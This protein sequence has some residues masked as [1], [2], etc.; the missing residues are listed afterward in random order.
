MKTDESD[1]ASAEPNPV[2]CV[3]NFLHSMFSPLNVSLKGKPFTLQETDYY[4]KAYFEKL[5]NYG[6]DAS[7]KRLVSSFW[8]HDS[9]KNYSALKDNDGYTTQINYL[10][11]GQTVEL[12][13]KLLADFI[14]TGKMLLNGVDMNIKLKSAIELFIF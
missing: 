3:N 14:S 13:G 9:H 5:L 2:G 4:Y 10:R 1:L 7:G 6:S 8:N 11:N 12:Y